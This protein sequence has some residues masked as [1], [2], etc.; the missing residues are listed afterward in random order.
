MAFF[1]TDGASVY[2]VVL[3]DFLGKLDSFF[4]DF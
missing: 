4:D 1:F 2:N 3:N